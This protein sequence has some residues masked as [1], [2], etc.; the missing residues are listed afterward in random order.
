M[1]ASIASNR[2]QI[3]TKNTTLQIGKTKVGLLIDSGS[4]CSLLNK[5]LAMEVV[6]NSTLARWLTTTP[7]QELKTIANEP[8]PVIGMMQAPIESNGW[9]IEFAEFVV[10]KDGLKP[11]IGRD[12]FEVLGIAITQTLC[13]DEGSMVNTITNQCPYKTRIE[14]QFPQNTHRKSKNTHRKPHALADQNFT[15]ENLNFTKNF[16]PNYHKDRRVPINLQERVNSEIKKLLKEGHTEKLN[17]C[18]D[19]YLISPIVITVKRDQTIKLAL[20]SKNLNKS[21]HKNKYQMPNIE[22]LMDSKSQITTDY[23]T[24]PAE[25]IYFSTID[26]KY[27]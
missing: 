9:R 16:Q 20:D 12:L 17:N 26:I 19:Q 27:A 10:V 21:R 7:A 14:N 1:A 13:S 8:I 22:T 23:K 5:S 2:I 3:E 11:L 25:K 4:V 15:L 6:N 24:K 18:S